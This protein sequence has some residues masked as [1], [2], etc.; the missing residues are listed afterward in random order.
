MLDVQE[1]ESFGGAVLVEVA[2][3]DIPQVTGTWKCGCAYGH[4]WYIDLVNRPT[5][6][7]FN[8]HSDGRDDW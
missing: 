3:A 2:M 7:V 4:R 5:V 6:V 8:Q 1:S